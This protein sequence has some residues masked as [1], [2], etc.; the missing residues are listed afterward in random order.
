MS[1][2]ISSD[3]LKSRFFCSSSTFGVGVVGFAG[4]AVEASALGVVAC[5]VPLLLTVELGC[6][7]APGVVRGELGKGQSEHPCDRA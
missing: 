2:E 1:S 7:G 4:F 6:V 3:G 5:A